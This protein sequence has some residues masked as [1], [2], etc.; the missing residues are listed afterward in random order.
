[1]TAP[2][3]AEVVGSLLRP[4]HLVRARA[5]RR[6]GLLGAAAFKQVE[7]R[8]VDQAIALQEGSGLGVVTD[9]E[10]RR[11]IFT[12]PVTENVDGLEYVPGVTRT[13]YTA[14]GPVQE[15]LPLVVTG[16]LRFRRSVATE[17]F[18]YARARARATVKVT[19]P[20]PLMMFLRW[21]PEHSTAAYPDAFAMAAD[22]AAIVREE[23]R[24]LAALGCRYVQIDAPEIATLVQQETRDWY[25]GQGI[26]TDRILTEGLDLLNSVTD[27][28]GV[29]FGVH[30]CRGN[31]NGRWMAAGG[32][33]H[34]AEALFRR[35]SGFHR[36]LLEYDD[37]RSGDFTPLAATPPDRTVVLGLVSTKTSRVETVDEIV[38]RV[39]EAAEHVDTDRLALSTQCGFASMVEAH[40][41]LTEDVQAAKLALVTD[42]AA[43]VWA[44]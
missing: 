14:Q 17:E 10:L 25:E 40:P 30:L 7:D 18:A 34:V 36:F 29:T 1:M 2:V 41:D 31:R 24:E 8:A 42:A 3:R 21:S 6:D 43:A 15:E 26:S 20:S 19:L 32:Y 28:E 9:G 44:D 11:G 38:S 33:D 13:W 22:A 23:V 4:A 16:T 35:C 12:G 37:E 5:A 39:R 27:V